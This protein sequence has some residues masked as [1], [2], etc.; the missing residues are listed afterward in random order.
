V[1]PGGE[2]EGVGGAQGRLEGFEGDGG[3]AGECGVVELCLRGEARGKEGEQAG[4]VAG[5]A[6]EG[7]VE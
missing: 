6:S 4:G 1:R 5:G 2:D 7:G 3:G